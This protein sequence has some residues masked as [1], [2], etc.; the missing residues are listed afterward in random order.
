M[1][2]TTLK[3]ARLQKKKK[4]TFAICFLQNSKSIK[5]CDFLTINLKS[6]CLLKDVAVWC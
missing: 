5:L 3:N 2:V 1:L 6:V 4:K